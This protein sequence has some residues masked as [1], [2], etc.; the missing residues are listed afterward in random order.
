MKRIVFVT[1]DERY[2]QDAIRYLPVHS[3]Q[4]IKTSYR[5]EIYSHDSLQDIART[6]VEQAY[7]EVKEPCFVMANSLNVEALGQFPGTHYRYVLETIGIQGIMKLMEGK[8][9]RHCVFQSCI[10]FY[11]GMDI[12][13]FFSSQQGTLATAIPDETCADWTQIFIPESYQVSLEPNDP[14]AQKK[15]EENCMQQLAEYLKHHGGTL[16]NMY[17]PSYLY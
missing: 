14:S 6:R 12:H 9:N 13:Y 4:L 8:E 10:A 2:Y 1:N 15:R 7:R 5:N 3:L 11:D 17:V 16:L